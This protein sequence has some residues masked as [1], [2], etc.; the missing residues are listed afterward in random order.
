MR[1]VLILVPILL[2]VKVSSVSS[3]S[4]SFTQ[5]FQDTFQEIGKIIET[6]PRTFP[7]VNAFRDNPTIALEQLL[8][9]PYRRDLDTA[10]TAAQLIEIHGYGFETHYVITDDGYILQLYRVFNPNI[11]SDNYDPILLIHGLF[12]SCTCWLFNGK[13]S[14]AFFLADE[15][16]DVWLMNV[17]GTTYSTN[18]TTYNPHIGEFIT[19][20]LCMFFSD[21]FSE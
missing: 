9:E 12:V 15:G 2:L 6:F 18:H 4:N 10:A 17:R 11:T 5:K 19:N 21:S 8:V 20:C 1:N 13:Q 14:V 3:A 7:F 16:K